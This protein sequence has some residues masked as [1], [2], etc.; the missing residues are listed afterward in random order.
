MYNMTIFTTVLEEELIEKHMNTIVNM[1]NSGAVH[2][3]KNDKKEG[4]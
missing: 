4:L 1:E 3:L 2:M